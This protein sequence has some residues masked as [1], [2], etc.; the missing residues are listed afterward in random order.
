MKRAFAT[1]DSQPYCWKV[2][3]PDGLGVLN[4]R[5]HGLAS[6][7]TGEAMSSLS[8]DNK[9]GAPIAVYGAMVANGLI[10]VAKGIAAV[11][12]GSSAML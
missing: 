8:V 10:A 5:V 6:L 2:R 4:A 1:R 7:H 3:L 11:Y 12:T 9:R